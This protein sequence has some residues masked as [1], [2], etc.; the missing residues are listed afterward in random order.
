MICR[1]CCVADGVVTDKVVEQPVGH[2]MHKTQ[3][4]RIVCA[5]CWEVGR[6]K[7]VADGL[8]ERCRAAFADH[9]HDVAFRKDAVDVMVGDHQHRADAA[10]RQ[11]LDSHGQFGVWFDADD[12][13]ALG[14][15]NCTYRHGRLR[16]STTPFS[17]RGHSFLS[18]QVVRRAGHGSPGACDLPDNSQ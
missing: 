12:L 6:V 13:V 11:Q 10:V 9:P 7:P 3:Y 1:V 5:G 15:E 2:P 16:I 4:R 17:G 14:I 18:R 8:I